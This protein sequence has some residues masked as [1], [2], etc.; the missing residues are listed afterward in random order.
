MPHTAAIP[1]SRPMSPARRRGQDAAPTGGTI[2]TASSTGT[3]STAEGWPHPTKHKFK[4]NNYLHR[5]L[6]KLAV[7][8]TPCG[9]ARQARPPASPVLGDAGAELLPPRPRQRGWSASDCVAVA[10]TGPAAPLRP[11]RRSER[12]SGARTAVT[13]RLPWRHGRPGDPMT[14]DQ[15]AVGGRA[16][17]SGH[18]GGA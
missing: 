12:P 7:S 6:D 9:P 3:H 5:K 15:P 2:L 11:R 13:L 16:P 18:Y 4:V 17:S 1:P 10:T 8:A 14:P